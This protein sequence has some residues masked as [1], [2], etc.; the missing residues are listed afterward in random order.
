MQ[1]WLLAL[2]IIVTC[3]I[4]AALI[5][6]VGI[7]WSLSDQQDLPEW[8]EAVAQYENAAR[9]PVVVT[10]TTMPNRLTSGMMK[11]SLISVL[12]QNP[13]PEKIELN[14]PYTLKRKGTKYVIP[15][16]LSESPVHIYRCEDEGPATKYLP[17]LRRYAK[18][19]P[20][21][22][23]FVIDDD[24]IMPAKLIASVNESMDDHPDKAICGHGNVLHQ[25]GS[26]KVSFDLNS[27]VEPQQNFISDLSLHGKAVD[28]NV[29]YQEVDIITGYNGFGIRPVF[30]DVDK[31]SDYS[32]LPKNARFVDDIVISARLAERNVPRIVTSKLKPFKLEKGR[33]LDFIV[34]WVKPNDNTED[35]SCTENKTQNNNNEIVKH[36]WK[37]W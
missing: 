25:K 32:D 1:N 27:F 36:F 6:G 24:M 31:L 33:L 9:V 34:N 23:L 19:N 8:E 14:V 3:G 4:M 17:T 20:Q 18:T 29:G 15:D 21:K 12:T 13:A 22:K 37:V 10:L 35:L 26:Q 16:W 28:A 7:L 2:L 5:I 30:F 11:T